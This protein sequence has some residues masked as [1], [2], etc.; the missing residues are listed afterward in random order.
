MVEVERQNVNVTAFDHIQQ[1]SRTCDFRIYSRLLTIHIVS[2]TLL[3]I[4]LGFIL[5]GS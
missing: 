5:I 4:L 1:L 2:V 3:I